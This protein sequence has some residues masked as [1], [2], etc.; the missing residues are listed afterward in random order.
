A[1]GSEDRTVK[2]W[3]AATGQLLHTF[4]G[5]GSPIECLAFSPDGATLA[6]GGGVVLGSESGDTTIRLWNVK[7]RALPRT[8][9]GHTVYVRGLAFSPDGTRLASCGGFLLKADLFV[10]DVA[11]GE[12]K[13]TLGKPDEMVAGVAWSPD[14]A[15]LASANYSGFSI[16]LWDAAGK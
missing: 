6:S 12:R 2:L 3:D 11:T 8:W 14:G 10:W 5:H 15:T 16:D 7:A 13:L 9:R 1:S 4:S